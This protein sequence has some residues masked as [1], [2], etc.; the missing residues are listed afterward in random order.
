MGVGVGFGAGPVHVGV[1]SSWSSLGTGFFGFA[2]LAIV[3]MCMSDLSCASGGLG[4]PTRLL[5]PQKEQMR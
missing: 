3:G 2:V 1:G 4:A 5:W